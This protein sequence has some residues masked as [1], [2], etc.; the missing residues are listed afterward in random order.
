[1]AAST[2]K[3]GLGVTFEVGN[4]ADPVV[5][6]ALA[7]VVSIEGPRRMREFVDSTHLGSPDNYREK[8]PHVKNSEVITLVLH[9]DPSS[10]AQQAIDTDFE[11]GRLCAFRVQYGKAGG[12][13]SVD[14]AWNRR[15]TFSGYYRSVSEG[16]RVDDMIQRTVEIEPT[17]KI[18][19]EANS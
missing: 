6:A 10:A 9:F 13:A 4:S 1:M 8:R 12:L 15:A 19:Y 3:V 11:S 14:T 18:T 2:G 16:I 5:Y 17:G 7:N